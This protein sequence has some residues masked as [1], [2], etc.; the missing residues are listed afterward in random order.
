M[1]PPLLS[2]VPRG[3]NFREKSWLGGSPTPNTRWL[4]T[5][6]RSTVTCWYRDLASSEATAAYTGSKPATP[7]VLVKKQGETDRKTT[8][9]CNLLKRAI[10]RTIFGGLT[11]FRSKIA[12]KWSLCRVGLGAM[13]DHDAPSTMMRLEHPAADSW[14]VRAQVRTSSGVC[15]RGRVR[16]SRRSGLAG[17]GS[18]ELAR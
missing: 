18:P 3:T 5:G 12:S 16:R 4:R 14:S 7:I 13:H 6:D 17:A 10:L 15:E 8:L 9:Q 11:Q 2:E 1:F